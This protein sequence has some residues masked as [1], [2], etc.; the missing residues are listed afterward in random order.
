MDV[1]VHHYP[2]SIFKN[3]NEKFWN[4]EISWKNK[5]IDYDKGDL[6]LKK[7]FWNINK[8]VQF[9]DGWHLFKT[10]M[11]FFICLSVVLYVPL[12]NWHSPIYN[13][14]IDFIIFGI[15]WNVVFSLFY[16]KLLVSKK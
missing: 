11:I 13:F 5:Y 8:P 14:F 10:L 2:K 3:L 1:L 15:T 16:N 12:Y 4:G 6:R 9:S 7:W